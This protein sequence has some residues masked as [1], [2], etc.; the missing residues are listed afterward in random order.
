M[1]Q[2]TSAEGLADVSSLLH[3]LA[4]GSRRLAELEGRVDVGTLVRQD[5][6][7]IVHGVLGPVV[8]LGTAGRAACQLSNP[9]PISASTATDEVALRE[10]TLM[11][12]ARGY[13]VAL[14]GSRSLRLNDQAGR[15]HVLYIRVSSGP[16]STA[17]V[18]T[19]IRRHRSTL[20]LHS[21]TLILVVTRP[22]NYDRQVQ[23]QR[24]LQVWALQ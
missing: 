4:I 18:K 22:E 7:R 1:N 11:A 15:E 17:W 9:R 21:S 10:A 13:T 6:I 19:L 5:L 14:V 8:T 24:H 16:P 3:D 2:D 20:R 23:Y 12:V